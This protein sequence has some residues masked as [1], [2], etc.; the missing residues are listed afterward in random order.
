MDKFKAA[1]V[2]GLLRTLSWLP[3]RANHALGTA[4]GWALWWL[5]NPVKRVSRINIDTAFPDKDVEQRR[6]LLKQ[7]LMELGKTATELGPIWFWPVD[8][9]LARVQRVEGGAH[10][11]AAFAQG[12]GVMML[13]P[14]IGAWEVAGLYM[15]Q[16]HPMT[17]LYRPPNLPALEPFML[18][19]RQRTG[20]RLLPTDVKGVR[21]L[22][23]ALGRNELV[24][25][26]PDQD[27][28]KRG[29]VHAP[30]FGHPARTMLLVSKLA[31]KTDCA[32]VTI[33]AERLPKG[34]G[35]VLNV[36]PVET[37]IASA[38]SQEAATALNQTVETL[39]RQFPAQYQWSYKRYK[40]PPSGV[41]N[42]YKTH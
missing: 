14:H 37:P 6:A 10:L 16:Y 11:Q 39:V 41:R 15:A 36:Q 4:L 29:S 9:V 21:G 26:L 2:R 30:F 8:K 24:G 19:V 38:E 31:S 20:A 42:P 28:G 12:R 34:Q 40:H 5:P 25:I 1:L 33:L 7:S 23:Q 3:L 18:T 32:A 22:R 27:P 17:T 13:S 35:Y